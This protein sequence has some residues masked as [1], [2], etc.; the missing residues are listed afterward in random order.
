[1]PEHAYI[2]HCTEGK[3]GNKPFNWTLPKLTLG[4][5]D[6]CSCS[7]KMISCLRTAQVEDESPWLMRQWDPCTT[8]PMTGTLWRNSPMAGHQMQ[9]SRQ[10]MLKLPPLALSE[11]IS[12]CSYSSRRG[13]PGFLTALGGGDTKENLEDAL[14]NWKAIQQMAMHYSAQDERLSFVAKWVVIMACKQTSEARAKTDAPG[15]SFEPITFH[16]SNDGPGPTLSLSYPVP[17]A[18]Q[19]GDVLQVSLTAPNSVLSIKARGPSE[20]PK[21]TLCCA[22]R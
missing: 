20:G 11:D 8:I 18:T 10:A 2:F 14:G 3:D 17:L 12:F 5:G 13:F 21:M 16:G 1:M 7:E 6:G 19:K 22:P 4:S 15:P 9:Q